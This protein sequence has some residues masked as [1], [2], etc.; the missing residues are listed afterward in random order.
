MGDKPLAPSW[1]RRCRLFYEVNAL[2]LLDKCDLRL[3]QKAVFI[4]DFLWDG[5]LAFASHPHDA[6]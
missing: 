1:D 3:G 4:T 5:H 2:T 6:S